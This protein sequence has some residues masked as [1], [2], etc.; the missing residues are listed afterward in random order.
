MNNADYKYED[1]VEAVKKVG[2]QKDDVLFSYSNIGFFGKMHN[3]ESINDYCSAFKKAIFE[4]IGDDGT[5]VVPTFS[6]SFCNNKTFDKNKTPSVCGVFT[7]YI[8]KHQDAKRSN[9]PNFSISAIGKHTE[10]FTKNQPS[11]PFDKDSFWERFLIKNGKF[12]NLNFDSG[13][14]FFHFVEKVINVP[15]RYD[16]KFLGKLKINSKFVEKEFF[17]FVYD[18]NKLEN[19]PNFEKFHKR[20]L[21]SQIAKTANLG[22]GQIVCISSQNTMDLIKKEI[23]KDPNFLIQKS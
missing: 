1:I 9:E 14:T 12:L 5:L 15:Y 17:H 3:A 21:M 16:K 11:H 4:V 23:K 19:K 10:F 13:S 7:E 22:K 20:A 8:R 18:K 2:I 6:Y